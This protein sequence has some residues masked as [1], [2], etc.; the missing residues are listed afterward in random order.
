MAIGISFINLIIPIENIEKKYLG[1]FEQYKSE[2]DYI[3][4]DDF[5][6]RIGTMN[7]WD[8]ET[9]CKEHEDFGLVGVVE[10]DGIKQWQDFCVVEWRPTLPCE[11]LRQDGDYV[12]HKNDKEQQYE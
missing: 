11:W 4:H 9:L 5:L 3:S 7:P 1:G 10:K 2:R 12:W 8:M 6:V